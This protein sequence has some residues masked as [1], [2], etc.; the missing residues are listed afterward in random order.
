V[1]VFAGLLGTVNSIETPTRQAFVSELVG[2]T[3]LP[4]ALSLNASVFNSARIA[5]PAIAGV[6]IATIGLGPTFLIATL[7]AITPVISLLRMRPAELYRET[8]PA[9]GGRRQAGIRDGLRYVWR[10]HDLVLAM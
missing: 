4:N 3:L 8:T 9:R 6:A 7:A 10:R 2:T 5:G 1:Y